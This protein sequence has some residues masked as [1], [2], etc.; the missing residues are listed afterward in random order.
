MADNF[1]SQVGNQKKIVTPVSTGGVGNANKILMLDASGHV[2]PS[3]LPSTNTMTESVTASASIS[4]KSAVNVYDNGGV[5]SVRP[6]D[7]TTAGSE[8]NA[9]AAAAITNGAVGNVVMGEQIVTGLT[10]LTVNAKYFLGTAG[11]YTVT[12]PTSSGN[13]VQEIGTATSATELF[14]SPSPTSEVWA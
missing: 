8:A 2:D 6:A 12:P 5:K 4:A 11:G 1:I 9:W 14:F 13:V 3:A 10:G 7:N